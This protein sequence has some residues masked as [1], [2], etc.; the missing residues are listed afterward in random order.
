MAEITNFKGQVIRLESTPDSDTAITDLQK[1]VARR[2]RDARRRKRLSRRALSGRSGVSERYL[3]QLEAGEGNISIGLLLRVAIALEHRIEWLV[4]ED[5]PWSSDIIQAMELFRSADQESREAALLALQP[6][7]EQNARANRL[8]LIGLRGAGKS[9]LGRLAAE[10]LGVPFLELNKEIEGLGGMPVAEIIALY[11]QEGYRHLELK[12]L[13]QVLEQHE[14]V[15]LAAAGGIVAEPKTFHRLLLHYNTIWLKASAEEH[16]DRVRAQGD[17]RPMA[18]NP[19]AMDQL[20]S[21]LR[22]REA[23]YSKADVQIDTSGKPIDVSL[24]DLVQAIQAHGF[25][26]L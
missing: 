5:D 18:D 16:M 11:G 8:C 2:V 4:G 14:Q 7:P 9:T 13:D 20:K 12:A 15:I 24:Q 3:A 6:K 21:I 1:L 25:L 22:N 19:G 17:E 10:K 26:D 23:L